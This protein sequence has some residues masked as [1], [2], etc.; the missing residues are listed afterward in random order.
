VAV[1]FD[2]GVTAWLR[3]KSSIQASGLSDVVEQ[4]VRQFVH[5]RERARGTPLS[6]GD[7]L[8]LVLEDAPD[9]ISVDLRK[10]LGRLGTLTPE[11]PPETAFQ[12]ETRLREA[13]ESVEPM[14]RGALTSAGV[15]DPDR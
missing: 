12:G 15:A 6:V 13:Y 2:E 10:L 8:V 7:R 11:E 9:W 4:F 14:V 1:W 5:G 3:A